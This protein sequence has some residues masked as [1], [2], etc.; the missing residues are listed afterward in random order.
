MKNKTGKVKFNFVDVVIIGII[1]ALI[2]AGTYKLFFVNRGLAAQNGNIEFSVLVEK[3]RQ[4]TVEGYK[5][6]QT[7]RDVQTNIV[8][9]TIIHNEPSPHKKAVPTL[10]GRVVQA[11]VPELYDI[12]VTISSPAI[13]TDNNITIG[14]KEIK[15]GAPISIKTNTASSTG[16]VYG[17]T[18]K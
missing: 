3:V 1:L 5:E 11:D 14:N 7:V 10:D 12:I 17:V 15:T 13:V 4:P 16:I 18:V 2:A 9:G 6:G 8:L